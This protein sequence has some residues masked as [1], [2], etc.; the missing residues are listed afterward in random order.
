MSSLKVDQIDVVVV[1]NGKWAKS[2]LGKY[3]AWEGGYDWEAF[4]LMM[5]EDRVLPSIAGLNPI[6]GHDACD[7]NH[8]EILKH[9]KASPEPI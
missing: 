1:L 9:A 5:G 2:R 3:W 8:D 6:S 7:N 4:A